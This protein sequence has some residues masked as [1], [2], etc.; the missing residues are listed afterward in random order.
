[1]CLRFKFE[2]NTLWKFNSHMCNHVHSVFRSKL[3]ENNCVCVC[4]YFYFFDSVGE[5]IWTQQMRYGGNI[6]NSLTPTFY[7][8]LSTHIM[9]IQCTSTL[10]FCLF[11]IDIS[12]I[13]MG[14][15]KSKF[16]FTVGRNCKQFIS[17]KLNNMEVYSHWT[18]PTRNQILVGKLGTFY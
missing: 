5:I 1:M 16:M 17:C 11:N 18:L 10:H 9:Y 8:C 2:R 6:E 14:T 7:I 12:N 13:L 3:V 4:V 15:N